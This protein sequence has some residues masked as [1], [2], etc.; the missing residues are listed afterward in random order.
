MSYR[1][2]RRQPPF[3][4]PIDGYEALAR[5]RA[6]AARDAQIRDRTEEKLR[7]L[8]RYADY[9]NLT[10]CCGEYQISLMPRHTAGVCHAVHGP[11]IRRVIGLAWERIALNDLPDRRA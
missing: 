9:I 1:R 6:A 11:D 5:Y 2:R 3:P 4:P 7:A 8:H 10:R